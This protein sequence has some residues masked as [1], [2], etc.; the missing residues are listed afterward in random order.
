MVVLLL[1]ACNHAMLEF[2]L[3]MFSLNNHKEEVGEKYICMNMKME[4]IHPTFV[5]PCFPAPKSRLAG[6]K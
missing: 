2:L 3:L 6:G 5:N 1:F 4:T